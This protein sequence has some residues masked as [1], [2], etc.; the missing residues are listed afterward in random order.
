MS[1]IYIFATNLQPNIFSTYLWEIMA[2]YLLQDFTGNVQTMYSF[3]ASAA[4]GVK[5][6]LE[7]TG[8]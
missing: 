1:Y 2:S 3:T 8:D 6:Y 5:S 7:N 4:Y